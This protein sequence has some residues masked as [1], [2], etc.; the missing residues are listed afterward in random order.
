MS[1]IVAPPTS[2]IQVAIEAGIE[3]IENRLGRHFLAGRATDNT[4][5]GATT[6]YFNPPLAYDPVL[7]FGPFGELASLTSVIYQPASSNPTTY[8]LDTH[9]WLLPE[10]APGWGRPYYGL[11]FKQRWWDPAPYSMTKALQITGL[12][13]Y[14]TS[15]PVD[16]WN[17]MRAAAALQLPILQRVSGSSVIP[18]GVKKWVGAGGVSTEFETGWLPT[19]RSVW[20]NA[21]DTAIVGKQRWEI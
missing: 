7:L 6:R 13:G 20:Q 8:T 1:G 11:R 15:I 21:V 14:G 16:V 18:F 4:E 2:E 3:Q 5:I 10:G 17:A 19:L 9:F 12:W